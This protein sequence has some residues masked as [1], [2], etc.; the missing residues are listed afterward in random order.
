[1]KQSRRIAAIACGF[2]TL[3]ILIAVAAIQFDTVPQ[4]F[5][6]I[7]YH[8]YFSVASLLQSLGVPAIGQFDEGMFMAP[9][10][11]VGKT[12]I[13]M[14]WIFIYLLTAC[15]VTYLLKIPKNRNHQRKH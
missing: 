13:A 1:M 15:L 4:F 6:W 7:T 11:A 5:A 9:V 10:T 8:S 2:G 14:F 3:H 12:L